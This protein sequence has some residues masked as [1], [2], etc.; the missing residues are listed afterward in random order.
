MAY[1]GSG[2]YVLPGPA[3]V[4]GG[5][6]DATEH[7]TL[8]NDMA[9][10]L[11]T[12]IT[13]DGQSPATAN[14]PLGGFKLTG[15]AAGTTAG[16]SVRYEQ[17][18]SAVA[19]TGGTIN[20]TTV[21]ATTADT[22]A[23]TTLS[24][25]GATT[26]AGV[27]SST[28]TGTGAMVYGTSPTLTTPALGTPSALVGTNI[29]G[30]AA[31]LTAGN[32]TTNANLTGPI[33]STGNATAVAAQTGTGSTFVMQSS[34]TLTTPVLGVATATTINKL[35][36]TAPAT[37]ATL[38]IADGATLATAGAFSATLTATGATNVTLPTTGTLAT[39]AGT[40]TLTNKTLT[41][42]TLTTPALGTPSAGVLTNCTGL[43]VAG[44]G[45]GASD[46]ATARTNLGLVIG[47]DVLAPN[48]SAASLTSFPTLN[49]N[50]SGT[51]AGLSATLAVASG[52]T[53]QTT[54]NAALN[55]L[56]PSQTSQATK[57]LQTDGTNTAWAAVS[58]GGTVTSVALSGG[59]TGLSVSGS[60]ITTSGTITLSGTL[61]VGSGG[62]GLT[63]PG[64]SGNV[65]TSN[66]TS[67]ASST[68]ATV[69]FASSAEN[70]AGTIENKAVDPLGIREAFNATGTAPV[71]ACRAW[72]NFNGTGTVAI[73]ASGNVSSITDNNVGYYTVNFATAMPDINYCITGCPSD[74]ANAATLISSSGTWGSTNQ[75]TTSALMF[76]GITGTGLDRTGVTF[77]FFR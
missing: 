66:G 54:A 71:F 44:G 9:T 43:P 41:S 75:T 24:A 36:V 23:F 34:P 46:A 45:T 1:N 65:L 31:G 39:I 60:P 38:T 52:G 27:T 11:T 25:S 58:A 19:I 30:T 15:L 6:V 32:V 3:L 49:Q 63:A 73:R 20:G 4:T 35:T 21:G 51:A 10:A 26:F 17:I 40:E 47:T 18:T 53:G 14:L 48:G 64:T 29:T 7:N 59:S 42:P 28:A 33:T 57:V 55:A 22:G 8:R 69:T 16:D 61:A 72:V 13:R 50:T 37:A 12:A 56:L 5:S 76:V 62:T 77:A 68:P 67:W 2:T 70:A 74:D